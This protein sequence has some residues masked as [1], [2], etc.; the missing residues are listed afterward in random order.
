[1]KVQHG[2]ITQWLNGSVQLLFDTV[3]LAPGTYAIEIEHPAGFRHVIELCK[4]AP[5][6][7]LPKPPPV[8]EP[9]SPTASEPAPKIYRDGYGKVI[10][11]VAS[12]L[13]ARARRDLMDKFTRRIEY[14]GNSRSGYIHYIEGTTRFRLLHEMGGGDCKFYIEVPAA[15][16][17]EQATGTPLSRR[18]EIVAWIAATVQGEKASSWRYEI[19]ADV[20]TFR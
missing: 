13:R 12:D 19:G 10:A 4:L 14:E 5:G 3:S 2:P 6:E 17:W 7:A 8:P 1:M 20:I 9:A 18:D 11:D 15:A 16:Q